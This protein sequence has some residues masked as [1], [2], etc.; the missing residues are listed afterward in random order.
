MYER[1][2]VGIV[3]SCP[4]PKEKRRELLIFGLAGVE[5]AMLRAGVEHDL[6][7]AERDASRFSRGSRWLRK[8]PGRKRGHSRDANGHDGDSMLLHVGPHIPRSLSCWAISGTICDHSICA[9][10]D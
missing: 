10:S 4:G 3:L 7:V 9:Q 5:Y 6:G 2:E 8:S 1:A